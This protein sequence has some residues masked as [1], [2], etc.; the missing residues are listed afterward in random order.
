MNID[1]TRN[2][3]ID[4]IWGDGPKD[5]IGD[6]VSGSVSSP[7]VSQQKQSYV[8]DNNP[9]NAFKVELLELMKRHK[10]N[11]ADSTIGECTAL[12]ISNLKRSM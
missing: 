4:M 6:L 1:K 2:T 11:L 3:M 10:F 9:I 12:F 7:R 8:E 5:E